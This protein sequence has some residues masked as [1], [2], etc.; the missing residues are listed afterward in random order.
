MFAKFIDL[1]DQGRSYTKDD[2]AKE[3]EL[4]SETLQAFI[5]YLSGQG[6]LLELDCQPEEVSWQSECKS[7]AACTRCKEQQLYNSVKFWE[8]KQNLKQGK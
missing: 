3:L 6:I 7:C 8:L 4:S 2:L 5:D 1:M